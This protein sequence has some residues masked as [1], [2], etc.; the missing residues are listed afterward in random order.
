MGLNRKIEN[1]QISINDIKRTADFMEDYK[2]QWQQKFD[3]EKA[4]LDSLPSTKKEYDNFSSRFEYNISFNDGKDKTEVNNYQWFIE[5]LAQLDEI[6]EIEI[7]YYLSYWDSKN[8]KTHKSMSI[9]LDFSISKPRYNRDTLEIRF[10]SRNLESDVEIIAK[11]LEDLKSQYTHEYQYQF[12]DIIK[13]IQVLKSYEDEWKQKVSY[14][15]A[16]L[17]QIPSKAKKYDVSTLYVEYNIEWYDGRNKR[18]KDYDW[19]ISS[20]ENIKE[21]KEISIEF[22]VSYFNDIKGDNRNYYSLSGTVRF[23]VG[24]DSYN[25]RTSIDVYS[26]NMESEADGLYNRTTNLYNNCDIRY[27]KLVKNRTIRIQSFSIAVG[28][29]LSYIIYVILNCV[30]KDSEAIKTI[31][32]NKNIIVFG[33]WAIAIISGNVFASWFINKLYE[34]LLPSKEYVGYNSNSRKSIYKDRVGEYT[35][36]SEV[37]IG[38]FSDLKEKRE[39]IEKCYKYSLIV[40]AIQF[41]ISVVLYLVLK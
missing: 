18:E 38:K 8:E 5:N 15:E 26:D 24:N 1:K 13:F 41:V 31:I 35:Q 33:Q 34:P 20:I 6:K 29:V 4:Y 25:S 37:Q 9:S 22:R 19:F 12:K 30:F 2:K 36:D 14:E 27:D 17:K 10:D 40:I 28:I 21:I 3:E 16:T 7:S 39:L 11:Q 23:G 32:S